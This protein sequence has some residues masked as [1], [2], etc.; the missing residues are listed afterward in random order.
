MDAVSGALQKFTFEAANK[1]GPIWSPNGDRIVFSWDAKGIQDLYEKPVEAAGNGALLWSSSEHKLPLDWSQDG[2]IL[3]LGFNAKTGTDLWALPL[4]GDK[5]PIR[6]AD[7]AANE[8][9]GRFSPD[10]HWIAYDSDETG[11]QEIYIQPFQRAGGKSKPISITGGSLPQWGLDGREL[12]Y[13]SPDNR[14]MAVPINLN[15]S[16][17]EASGKPVALFALP[18]LSGGVVQSEYFA[19]RDGQRFLISKI[20]KDASPITILFNWKPPAK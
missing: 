13:V 12:F 18:L 17:A 11:R 9:N 1:F 16:S 19:S 3:Y 14:L 10:S 4:A 6:V 8:S 7:T 5:K 20:V 2:F 15:G